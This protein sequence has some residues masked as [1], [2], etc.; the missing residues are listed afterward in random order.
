MLAIKTHLTT[1]ART[2]RHTHT[3]NKP[4]WMDEQRWENEG[5]EWSVAVLLVLQHDTSP[6]TTRKLTKGAVSTSMYTVCVCVKCG[7]P[8]VVGG[9]VRFGSM[10]GCLGRLVPSLLLA[11]RGWWPHLPLPV[12]GVLVLIVAL[13]V[14]CRG[15]NRN[16]HETALCCDQPSWLI[17]QIPPP[18]PNM[19]VQRCSSA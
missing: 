5:N 1:L 10:N 2:R 7:E 16:N 17:L 12:G 19:C 8:A 18:H 9:R 14:S 15:G 6:T 13:S 3:D 11:R 4:W